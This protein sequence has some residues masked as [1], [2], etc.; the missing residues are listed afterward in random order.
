MQPS[1]PVS[2]TGQTPPVLDGIKNLMAMMQSGGDSQKMA[3]LLLTRHP[4]Y[5]NVMGLIN[6]HGGDARAAFYAEAERLGVDP[7][8]ILG[9]LQ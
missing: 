2:N 7:N 6:Q 4:A 9:M 8:S 5:N 1:Q 3:E